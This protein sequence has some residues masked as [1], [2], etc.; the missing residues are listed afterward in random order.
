[1][2]GVT[3]RWQQL[4]TIFEVPEFAMGRRAHELWQ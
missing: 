1:M 2:T 4:P 3:D